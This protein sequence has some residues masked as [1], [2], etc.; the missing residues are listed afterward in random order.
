[1]TTKAK[2]LEAILAMRL[3]WSAQDKLMATQLADLRFKLDQERSKSAKAPATVPTAAGGKKANP[4]FS[5]IDRLA[6]QEGQLTR[7]LRLGAQRTAGGQYKPSSSPTEVRRQLWEKWAEHCVADL[8][9]SLWL[10]MVREAGVEITEDSIGLPSNPKNLP[11][12][13]GAI[14]TD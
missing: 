1:M 10:Y 3:E 7:R 12:K 4:I 11:T 6:K 9:P 5:I 2:H 14:Q 13:L 8:M